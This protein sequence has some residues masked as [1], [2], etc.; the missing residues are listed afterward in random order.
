DLPPAAAEG[1]RMRLSDLH[2]DLPADLIATRPARP[3]SSARLL[4]AEGDTIADRHVSDLPG[5]L[6]PGDRL[7]LN[8]TRVIP[9]RLAGERRRQTGQGPATARVEVTLLE[10]GPDGLGA[11]LVKPLR[12]LKEGEGVRFSSR[13]SA[14]VARIGDGQ[15]ELAFNLAGPDFDA[16]LAEAGD[17]PLPPYIAALRAPDAADREDYHTIW[18]RHA[19]AVAAPTA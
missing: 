12:K 4:V 10:P 6:R 2:F 13:L 5:L 18:A 11:A 3:R 16:A 15:A 19:G 14:R 9:A 17:M 8:D 1:V 7:V